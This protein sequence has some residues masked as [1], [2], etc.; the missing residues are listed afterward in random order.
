MVSHLSI[1]NY[2]SSDLKTMELRRMKGSVMTQWINLLQNNRS[3]LWMVSAFVMLKTGPIHL[4][5]VGLMADSL[6]DEKLNNVVLEILK[7]Q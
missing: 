5:L 7:I 6:S 1:R 2:F 4:V 3:V